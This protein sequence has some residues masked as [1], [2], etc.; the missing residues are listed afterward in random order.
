[1][2]VIVIYGFSGMYSG[3]SEYDYNHPELGATH[4]CMLFFRQQADTDDY[5]AAQSECQRF[6]F[7]DIAFSGCGAL[8]VDVLNTDAYRG[9]AGL[10]E[11]ALS[12]GSALVYYPNKA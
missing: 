10:Y 4:K 3:N 6:G 8:Q 7:T 1:M 11:E 2:S 9:F 12:T 5:A